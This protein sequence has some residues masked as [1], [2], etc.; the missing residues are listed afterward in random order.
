MKTTLKLIAA[1]MIAC[2]GVAGAADDDKK[3]KDKPAKKAR[4]GGLKA[5]DK[6]KDGKITLDEL[7]AWGAA[8]DK[9][10]PEKR[11]AALF[12]K[13]DANGD[14]AISGDELKA[15]RKPKPDA[16]KPKPEGKKPGKKQ[17]NDAG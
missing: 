3:G 6:D 2:V 15:G 14:G 16:K 11:I 10:V 5:A 1:V 13:R 12:K 7:K 9:P 17:D 8:K 4:G